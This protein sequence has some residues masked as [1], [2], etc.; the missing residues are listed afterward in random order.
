[1][2][3]L[4]QNCDIEGGLISSTVFFE[5]FSRLDLYTKAIV[6]SF[7]KM[8]SIANLGELSS[9]Q[10]FCVC[11]MRRTCFSGFQLSV[12]G[13]KLPFNLVVWNSHFIELPDSIGQAIAFLCSTESQ[14][15]SPQFWGQDWL[16]GVFTLMFSLVWVQLQ[17]VIRVPTHGPFMW[18]GLL[19]STHSSPVLGRSLLRRSKHPKEPGVVIYNLTSNFT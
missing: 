12:L 3:N 15:L 19:P 5:T 16:G 14:C 18:Q 8:Q 6:L 10:K 1:M 17:R 4:K 13:S 2:L 9:Q 7:Q 11:K